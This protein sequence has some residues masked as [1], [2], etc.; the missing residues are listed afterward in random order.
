MLSAMHTWSLTAIAIAT[1]LAALY[2]FARFSDQEK[3][4]LAKR[5]VRANLYAFRLF[6]DEPFLIFRAQWQ[7]LKWNGRY[8]AALLRPAAVMSIP[9]LVLLMQLD[10]VYG[11]RT[12]AAGEPVIVTAQLDSA[13]DPRTWAPTLEGRGVVVETPPVRLPG[14]HQVCWRVRPTENAWGS[15]LLRVPGTEA[16]KTVQIG[17]GLYYI[18]LRRVA[19]LV[20]WLHYPGEPRLPGSAVHWIEVAYPYADIDILGWGMHWLI[21][22]SIVCMLTMFG[23][24]KRFGVTF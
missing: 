5:K 4:D 11:H 23:L 15:V 1:G 8:L 12:L 24:R 9:I 16:G 18:S 6:V 22:F 14:E 13:S 21:W 3:I 2:V 10:A 19:S 20:D 17:S 7:L